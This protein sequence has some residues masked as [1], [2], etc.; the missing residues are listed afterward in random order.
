MLERP[1][2]DSRITGHR[3]YGLISVF[4]G[5][6]RGKTTAG[7]GTAV[8]AIG[9]GKR[10][11]IVYFD[12]GGTT[13]YSERK[14]LDQIGI[15]WFATGRD[16]IDPVT[17]RFDFSVTDVDKL[18]AKRG[19][20]IVKKLFLEAGHDLIVLDEINCTVSLGMLD[21]KETLEVL[22]MKSDSTELILTGRNAPESFL[23]LAHL[24]TEMTLKKHYFYSGVPAR[25]GMDY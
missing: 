24:V 13:H 2:L 6:G 21:E 15:D 8:R 23:H 25:E 5:D 11:A 9:A 4:T 7:L 10:V 1:I 18:E 12:K 17:G 19:L 16:R 14:L 22:S 20:G 3:G